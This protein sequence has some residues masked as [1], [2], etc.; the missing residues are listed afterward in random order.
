MYFFTVGLLGFANL[1]LLAG[2][3]NI[4]KA[5]FYCDM[6]IQLVSS[7]NYFVYHMQHTHCCLR[8]Y[9]MTKHIIH[10]K[11]TSLHKTSK[12]LVFCEKK[13]K[14]RKKI[15]TRIHSTKSIITITAGSLG[16]FNAKRKNTKQPKLII[17]RPRESQNTHLNL[18]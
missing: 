3:T 13:I 5:A 12:K 11:D 9:K 10:V 1:G 7:N 18:S 16:F 14:E 17:L 8:L 6:A 4:F 15:L 2:N